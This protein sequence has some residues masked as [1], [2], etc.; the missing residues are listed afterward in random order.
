MCDCKVMVNKC[1]AKQHRI[2]VC[3][4]APIVKKKKSEKAKDKM[5]KTEGDKE[6][7]G[8]NKR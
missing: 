5:V 8:Q 6:S 1:V 4:M 3:K 2:V 7:M